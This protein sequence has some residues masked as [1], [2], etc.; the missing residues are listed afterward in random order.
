MAID[1][2]PHTLTGAGKTVKKQTKKSSPKLVSILTPILPEAGQQAQVVRRKATRPRKLTRKCQ[3]T[4]TVHPNYF[5]EFDG[6][7]PLDIVQA[8][9]SDVKY[10]RSESRSESE[11]IK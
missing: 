4:P 11:V 2:V 5:K 8:T 1:F 10:R 6:L 7:N 9:F 3:P